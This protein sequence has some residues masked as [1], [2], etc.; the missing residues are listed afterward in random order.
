LDRHVSSL[1]V[2]VQKM[3][4]EDVC[5][6]D[7]QSHPVAIQMVA[8]AQKKLGE[9]MGKISVQKLCEKLGEKLEDIENSPVIELHESVIDL[10]NQ[11]PPEEAFVVLQD[12]LK[13]IK[14]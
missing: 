14:K 3:V 13:R 10:V 12:G 7:S 2:L 11:L 6:G 5:S 4:I 8:Y 9:E 1:P